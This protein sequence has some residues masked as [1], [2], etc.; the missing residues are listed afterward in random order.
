MD[1]CKCRR[2]RKIYGLDKFLRTKINRV[3]RVDRQTLSL[4]FENGYAGK[5]KFETKILERN[6][7]KKGKKKKNKP[8]NAGA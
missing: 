3:L 1:E 8:K 4:L 6:K 2:S 5:G 7:D